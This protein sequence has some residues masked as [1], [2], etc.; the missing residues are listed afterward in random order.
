MNLQASHTGCWHGFHLCEFQFEGYDA[1][2]V[3]PKVPTLKRNF[4]IKTE[5]WNAFTEAIEI[6]LLENGFHLCYPISSKT[7]VM[8]GTKPETE[9]CCDFATTLLLRDLFSQFFSILSL[10]CKNLNNT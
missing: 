3:F 1:I 2:I 8:S 9:G 6:P 7:G 10:F 4:A 5:Y